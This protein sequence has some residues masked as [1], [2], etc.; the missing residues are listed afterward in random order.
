MEFLNPEKVKSISILDTHDGQ[1]TFGS[2][3]I[4]GTIFIE[5]KKGLRRRYGVAG[6]QKGRKGQSNNFAQRKAGELKIVY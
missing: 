4:N 2:K 3:G 1:T 6:L 5:L